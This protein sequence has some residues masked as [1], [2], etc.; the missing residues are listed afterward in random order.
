VTPPSASTPTSWHCTALIS[1]PSDIESSVDLLLAALHRQGQIQRAR[2]DCGCSGSD[3]YRTYTVSFNS[4]AEQNAI[5]FLVA[6]L[7]DSPVAALG[8]IRASRSAST[9]SKTF[10]GEAFFAGGMTMTFEQY[11][12]ANDTSQ[13]GAQAETFIPELH[14]QTVPIA[15]Q[16]RRKAEQAGSV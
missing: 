1:A 14:R 11:S 13:R 3:G 15:N 10:F 9:A 8:P 7:M 6:I 2:A 12:V 5:F 4:F 16:S